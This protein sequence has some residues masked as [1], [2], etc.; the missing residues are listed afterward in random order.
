MFVAFR[1][2][3]KILYLS[4][5]GGSAILSLGHNLGSRLASLCRA[6]HMEITS[7]RTKIYRPPPRSTG[8]MQI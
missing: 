1:D 8:I 6:V 7:T 3:K 5:E 4:G 2:E